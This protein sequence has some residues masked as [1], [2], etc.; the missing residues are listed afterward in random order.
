MQRFLQDKTKL[1][2][3]QIVDLIDEGRSREVA[4]KLNE[5]EDLA[6]LRKTD[7]KAAAKI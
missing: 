6:K 2:L 4:E 7:P 1:G 3:C 5:K